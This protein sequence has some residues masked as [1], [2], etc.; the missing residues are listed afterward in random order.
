MEWRQWIERSEE[1]LFW[2]R[3]RKRGR[4]MWN[5]CGNTTVSTRFRCRFGEVYSCFH[6]C[7]HSGTVPLF[8]MFSSSD[9]NVHGNTKLR[10]GN[11]FF[12]CFRWGNQTEC[13]RKYQFTFRKQI[14]LL[15][16]LTYSDQ[17]GTET[18]GLF[19]KHFFFL[20][21][22]YIGLFQ[23]SLFLIFLFHY[24]TGKYV[25]I[26][27]FYTTH[28]RLLP[29][30]CEIYAPLCKIK[31]IQELYFFHSFNK[32]IL[33]FSFSSIDRPVTIFFLFKKYVY[34][35]SSSSSFE[36]N[37]HEITFLVNEH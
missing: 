1:S 15:F 11:T 22:L 37:M 2:S 36:H 23:Y 5:R 34:I 17:E 7:G 20:F 8:Y 3:R 21:P 30:V 14:F 12:S 31:Q 4:N 13:R 9:L 27:R 18:L 25:V 26:V 10:S 19:Q 28:N 29:S 24:R 33:L 6:C 35:R 32:F 16:L